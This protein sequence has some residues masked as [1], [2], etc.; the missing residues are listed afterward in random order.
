MSDFELQPNNSEKYTDPSTLSEDMVKV[1]LGEFSSVGKTAEELAAYQDWIDKNRSLV[2]EADIKIHP[3]LGNEPMM[4]T[5]REFLAELN[6]QMIQSGVEG[7][8]QNTPL[9]KKFLEDNK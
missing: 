6:K 1:L 4:E 8:F 3:S 2:E 9:L 5:E 7:T